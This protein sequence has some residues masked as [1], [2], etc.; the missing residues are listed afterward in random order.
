MCVV[1]VKIAAVKDGELDRIGSDNAWEYTSCMPTMKL[2]VK[3]PGLQGIDLN[4][5]LRA[6]MVASSGSTKKAKIW[7]L[8]FPTKM[9]SSSYT[10]TSR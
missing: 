4:W 1:D 5:Q 2:T 3:R 8:S 7:T 6:C 10:A 9:S